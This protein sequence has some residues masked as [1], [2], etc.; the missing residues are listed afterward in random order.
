MIDCREIA[1]LLAMASTTSGSEIT[2]CLKDIQT[3]IKHKDL[4]M[5]PIMQQTHSKCEI[6]MWIQ[7]QKVINHS[8]IINM[9][10]LQ[11]LVCKLKK[12]NTSRTML[13]RSVDSSCH[14]EVLAPS[15]SFHLSTATTLLNQTGP[16]NRP[17]T[18]RASDK[19]HNWRIMQSLLKF[20]SNCTGLNQDQ[21]S[22]VMRFDLNSF[23]QNILAEV[24]LSITACVISARRRL[25]FFY[26]YLDTAAVNYNWAQW[27][28]FSFCH[29]FTLI[30]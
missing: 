11:P 13:V 19:K 14:H 18:L 8:L 7:N 20:H 15:V 29:L 5:S 30:D 28:E 12:K 23:M 4:R 17:L 26:N 24:L 2:L 3:T 10:D 21:N 27:H 9:K 16:T 25:G 6:N 22:R 1:E